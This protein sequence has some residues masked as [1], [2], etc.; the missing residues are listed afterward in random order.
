MKLFIFIVE[1]SPELILT[2]GGMTV[3]MVYDTDIFG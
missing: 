3:L 1:F 2:R